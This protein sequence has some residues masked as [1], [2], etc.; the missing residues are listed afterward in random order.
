[1]TQPR[2]MEELREDFKERFC[3][4]NHRESPYPNVLKT[5]EGVMWKWIQKHLKPITHDTTK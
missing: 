5:P 1:M 2:T 4:D 3:G